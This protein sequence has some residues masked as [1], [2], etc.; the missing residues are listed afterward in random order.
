MGCMLAYCY[1]KSSSM[2]T[3]IILHLLWSLSV[4]ITDC[5]TKHYYTLFTDI[6]YLIATI[7]S[8][9]AIR[10]Y[11]SAKRTTALERR[12]QSDSIPT[13]SVPDTQE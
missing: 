3:P 2:W 9:F 4:N 6:L 11:L 1:E 10:E 12:K 5:F 13:D 7:V 8:I